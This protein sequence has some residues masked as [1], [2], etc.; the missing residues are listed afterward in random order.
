MTTEK[1]VGYVLLGM[2]LIFIIF[3]VYSMYEVF[4]GTTKPPA[5]FKMESIAI[6]P[7]TVPGVEVPPA[8]IE[9]VS[10]SEVSKVVNLT[11]W[12]MLMFFIASVGNKI[13]GL[14]VKLIREIKVEVKGEG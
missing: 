9:L 4:T 5:I 2:G 10:G 3:A 14:G 6:S 11:L 8:K 7:P 13:A 12:Y 1:I